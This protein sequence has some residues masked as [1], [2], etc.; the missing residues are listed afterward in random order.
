MVAGAVIGEGLVAPGMR[1]VALR[2]MAF[3]A[4]CVVA[5]VVMQALGLVPSATHFH[6]SRVGIGWDPNR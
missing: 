3:F 1:P 2:V 5:V 4:F 6:G